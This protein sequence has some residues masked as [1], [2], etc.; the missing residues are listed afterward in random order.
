MEEVDDYEE[1]EAWR[2][3]AHDR[4]SELIASQWE[5]ALTGRVR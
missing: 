2:A 4:R 5:D 1:V 3:A